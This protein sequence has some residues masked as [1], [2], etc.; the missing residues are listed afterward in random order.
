VTKRE[1]DARLK[2]FHADLIQLCSDYKKETGFEIIVI[3]GAPESPAGFYI[4]DSAADR[5][6]DSENARSVAN[7]SPTIDKLA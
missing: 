6:F 7:Q 3:D 5:D 1:H 4:D 2:R